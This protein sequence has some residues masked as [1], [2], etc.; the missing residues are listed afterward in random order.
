MKSPREILLDGHSGIE[1]KLDVL[2]ERV[3]RELRDDAD[4]DRDRGI[5]LSLWEVLRLP[6]ILC[7][8]LA[9]AWLVIIALNVASRE[10][11]D[12]RNSVARN[13]A[14][15]PETRQALDEQRQ[16]FAELVGAIPVNDAGRR[17]AVP[18]PRSET[19][20]LNTIV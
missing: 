1:P 17:R 7:R 8:G 4:V 15:S 14:P 9:A 5:L 18:G 2:R 12:L 3:L 13:D 6:P 19:A 11:S 16:L 10:Q 20:S